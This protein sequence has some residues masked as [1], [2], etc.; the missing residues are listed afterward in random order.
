MRPLQSS[1]TLRLSPTGASLLE[2]IE[3]RRVRAGIVGLGYVGLPLA[4]EFARGGMTVT[5]IEL[6][7]R[8]A[9][10][11]AEGTSY[12]PDVP[13]ADVRALRDAGHLR[14]TTDFS[15][16]RELDTVNICVPTPL[17]KTK[18]P[19]MSYVVA[20]TEQIARYVHPVVDTRNALGGNRGPH[21]FRLGAPS[22]GR[23]RNSVE[24]A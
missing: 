24:A 10:A 16:I 11:I 19:D 14:A 20:A 18:D 4:V 17:R 9:D 7:Q 23:L 8:K 6:D 3:Q 2:R 5:G 15:V 22:R 13:T 12:V 1:P 21:L